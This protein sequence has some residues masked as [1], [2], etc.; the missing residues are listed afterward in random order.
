MF[1]S[2]DREQASFADMNRDC[3]SLY[4]N[5]SVLGVQKRQGA[6]DEPDKPYKPWNP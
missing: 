6:N 5:R 1:M 2:S 3:T 4:V